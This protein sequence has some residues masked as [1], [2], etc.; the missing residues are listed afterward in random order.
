MNLD[1]LGVSFGVRDEDR[2][3]RPIDVIVRLKLCLIS[4]VI[5][6]TELLPGVLVLE[7]VARLTSWLVLLLHHVQPS[8]LILSPFLL[9]SYHLN[10]LTLI[11]SFLCCFIICSCF[12]RS[13]ITGSGCMSIEFDETKILVLLTDWDDK[14]RESVAAD[15]SAVVHDVLRGNLAIKRE[16]PLEKKRII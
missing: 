14:C 10:L 12:Y 13:A 3:G 2:R 4:H 1:E 7:V 11:C 8:L 9:E 16:P 6:V 5:V 15:H